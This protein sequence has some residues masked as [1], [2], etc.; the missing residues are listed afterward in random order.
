M[1]DTDNDTDDN[2]VNDADD[3]DGSSRDVDR[4]KARAIIEALLITASEPV[5]PGRLTNLLSGYNGRDIREAVDALNAQYE[6][7]GHGI[8]VVEIAGGYYGCAGGYDGCTGC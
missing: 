4:L 8:L 5:T 7:A 2:V 3:N 6:V 1:S